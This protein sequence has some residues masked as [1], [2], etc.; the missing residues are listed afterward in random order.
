M[1]NIESLLADAGLEILQRDIGGGGSATIHKCRVVAPSSHFSELGMLVAAKEYRPSILKTPNQLERIKQEAELGVK[2]RHTNV[3]RAFALLGDAK[4]EVAEVGLLVLLL[5]WVDGVTLDSWYSTTSRTPPWESIR[6]VAR[7]LVAALGELHQNNVFHRD[8]KPENVMVRIGTASAVLM[9]IG[10]AELASNDETTLHTSVKDFVGSARYASPQFILGSAPFTTA[11][12]VYSLGA[13]LFL[14][15][16]GTPIFANIDRKSVIPIEVVRAPPEVQSVVEG[17]P[18]SMRVLLQ[19]MLS[20]DPARR[21]TLDQIA[22]CLDNTDTA[23]YLTTELAR[24]ADDTRS[25]VVLAVDGR[26]CFAD[27]AGD[28][29]GVDE[30]YTIVR[31]HSKELHVPSY[32][33]GVTPEQWIADATLKHVHQNIGHF[34]IHWRRWKDTSNS[35]AAI[36][37]SNSGQWVYEDGDSLAVVRGD[38]ILRKTRR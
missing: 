18:A 19:G 7:D 36:S 34:A 16:T 38:R 13:T 21:P 24:Q 8:V 20:H 17:V 27:L 26:S 10:V 23:T 9:D 6:A 12:D 3:V 37:M 32:K 5:E 29:P 28:Y 22:E 14:L 31:S 35:L 25:Y 30:V 11:D 4:S 15:I 33:R 2:I 1:S